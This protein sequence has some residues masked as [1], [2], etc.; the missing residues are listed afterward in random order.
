MANEYRT[1]A[2]RGI[3]SQRLKLLRTR[4]HI[5]SQTLSELCGL[6]K[7]AVRKYERSERSPGPESLCALADFFN[8]STDYLLGRTDHAVQ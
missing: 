8:V 2:I 5:S 3:F 1:A 6:G 7:D 4:R